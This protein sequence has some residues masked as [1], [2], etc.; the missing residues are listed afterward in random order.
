MWCKVHPHFRGI[1]L[2]EVVV[3]GQGPD[4][5]GELDNEAW[6]DYTFVFYNNIR[7]VGI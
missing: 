5:D 4:S 1:E 7:K 3:R 2:S 6:T